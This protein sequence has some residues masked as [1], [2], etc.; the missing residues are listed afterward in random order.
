M[1]NIVT[2]SLHH[3]KI[4]ELSFTSRKLL[5]TACLNSSSKLEEEIP[6]PTPPRMPTIVP[7]KSTRELPSRSLLIHKR[8]APPPP[9]ESFSEILSP[10]ALPPPPP[11]FLTQSEKNMLFKDQ[12]LG[13]R[14]NGLAPPPV[15]PLPPHLLRSQSSTSSSPQRKNGSKQSS[16]YED[17]G[18]YEECELSWEVEKKYQ[19][20]VLLLH[21]NRLK[22]LPPSLLES[23]DK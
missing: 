21:H 11:Q 5:T 2:L 20:E 15:P 17:D 4:S 8:P 10:N 16:L 14:Q 3:N 12:Q 9:P 19:L 1:P 13:L 7:F 23:L 22:T 18:H 6:P